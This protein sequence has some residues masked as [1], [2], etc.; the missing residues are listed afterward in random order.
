[1]KH[2]LTILL[3]AFT[4]GSSFAQEPDKTLARV[5]YTFTHIS[6]TNQRDKPRVENMLLAIGKNASVYTSYDKLNQSLNVS[7]MLAEQIKN[8]IGSNDL[9]FDLSTSAKGTVNKTSLTRFDYYY[10]AKERKFITRE[11]LFNTYL[12]EE[13]AA[14][15][16]WKILKDTMSFSGIHCQKASANF[17]GRNW[18]AW[19]A[20]ALPFQ[21][22]PWKLNGLPGLIIEAYDDKKEVKFEFAGLENVTTVNSS[23]NN[24]QQ[25]IE[26]NG[27]SVK[28][29]GLDV[30]TAYLGPVISLPADGIKTSRKDLDKLK[31]ARDKDPVGFMQAQTAGS[32]INGSIKIQSFTKAPGTVTK[33]LINNPIELP[34]KK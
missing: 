15:I 34:E 1:M 14:V 2:P 31:D 16:D 6:D 4:V 11:R 32:G 12:I 26:S 21:S 29:I 33:N 7:K 28:V 5:H 18:V 20:T 19:Y 8:Q 3:I 9:K 10:F 30:S 22:G 25:I 17:K 27:S 23:E 13:T 24:P